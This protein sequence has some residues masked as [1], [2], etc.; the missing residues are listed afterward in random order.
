MEIGK[1]VSPTYLNKA[2]PEMGDTL[3]G[4]LGAAQE[5]LRDACDP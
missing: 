3:V 2:T 5:S 1:P 4:L